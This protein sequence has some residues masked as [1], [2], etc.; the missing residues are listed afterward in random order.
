M[1]K[2]T[3]LL[4]IAVWGT[5]VVWELEF[6]RNLFPSNGKEWKIRLTHGPLTV[7]A[8]PSTLPKTRAIILFGSGD[9][10]WST[11]EEAIC[12]ACQ[13]QGYEMIGIDSV[14]YAETDYDLAT[15]QTDFNT[16]AQTALD[17]FGK[18]PPPLIVGGYSMGAA[19]AIAV[20]GGPNPPQKLVG[21]LLVDVLNR[22]RYGL[23]SADRLNILPTGPGTFSM[24]DFA[25]SMDSLRVVQWHA[26]D[27]S[28]DSRSWLTSLTAQHQ[29]HD[30]P[31]TGHGYSNNREEFIRE[32]VA[33]IDWIVNPRQVPTAKQELS[34]E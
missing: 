29:E 16:I 6:S 2:K 12:Q 9:G 1:L 4:L 7:F 3:F 26:E 13:K 33:S 19:Q 21:V 23:R 11:F 8:F 15:L 27:D 30:F 20:A 18:K 28:I 10:G 34:H 17:P 5:Y 32:F 22:G 24:Q 31:G 14:A 25:S